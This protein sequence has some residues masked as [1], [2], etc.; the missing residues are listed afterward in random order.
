MPL[1][2]RHFKVKSNCRVGIRL[3]QT[4][5][6]VGGFLGA[7]HADDWD[8][9]WRITTLDGGPRA[10]TYHLAVS[11]SEER[12]VRLFNDSGRPLNVL[13]AEFDEA[14]L[15]LVSSHVASRPLPLR[16]EVTRSEDQLK[17]AWTFVHPQYAM[18][19]VLRGVRVGELTGDWNP[20]DGLRA[21]RQGA[22]LDATTLLCESERWQTFEEFSEFWEQQVEP[23]FYFLLQNQ[24]YGDL[25]A[26]G[27][28]K[29][30]RRIFAMASE[31]G[32]KRDFV[33]RFPEMVRRVIQEVADR[34]PDRHPSFY[35]VS[36]VSSS[37]VSTKT[38]W[39][40]PVGPDEGYKCCSAKIIEVL[41]EV[42]I[43][44]DPFRL[45]S[46]PELAPI[47]VKREIL[48]AFMWPPATP[49]MKP[50]ESPLGIEI[51]RRGLALHLALNEEGPAFA[52]F[53]GEDFPQGRGQLQHD[54]TLTSSQLKKNY[55][56]DSVNFLQGWGYR[57]GRHFV[58]SL[59][60]RF[61]V[62]Q[63]LA[64]D[65]SKILEEWDRYLVP[66]AQQ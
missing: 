50:N 19:G 48:A 62:N 61:G 28:K 57:W 44:F 34:F 58:R 51:F 56:P 63:L 23:D 49:S 39:S 1:S 37:P 59:V 6:L 13:S 32:G 7:A 26:L 27:K 21:R 38:L 15:A 11:G 24:L 52:S 54:L 40:R 53:P 20:F 3:L 33:L 36:S 65:H 17:G 55:F 42:Y 5:L 16:L 31:P 29:E 66:G 47:V 14:K 9:V 8:G 25:E 35:V 64:L 41:D 22:F 46:R 10:V 18:G 43:C 2:G 60:P 45:A 4:A 12:L 30:L